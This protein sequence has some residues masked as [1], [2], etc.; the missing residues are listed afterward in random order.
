MDKKMKI[1]KLY[2]Y[3]DDD[4]DNDAGQR[5]HFSQKRSLEPPAQVS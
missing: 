3:N 5:T 1:R 4:N 2:D